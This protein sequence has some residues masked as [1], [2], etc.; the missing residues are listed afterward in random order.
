MHHETTTR[1][2]SILDAV[3]AA[4][5]TIESHGIINHVN[6]ATSRLFGYR[7]NEIVGQNV[8]VLM[9]SP[10][11]EEHDQYLKNHL[12]TG[13]NKIIGIG[14]KVLGRHK[15]GSTFA[16]HLSVAR[17]VEHDQVFFTG[18]IH[19]LSELERE[20]SMRSRLGQIVEESVN[21]I[22]TF[23]VNT[24]RF[25]SANRQALNNLGYKLEELQTMTPVDIVQ[26]LSEQ[27][28]KNTIL[29]LTSGEEQRLHLA[30]TLVR[31]DETQYDVEVYLHLTKAFDPPELVAIVKDVSEQNRMLEALRQS[32]K[33]E[34]IGNLTGGIAHDFN[35]ILTV[36]MGNLELLDSQ[37][38]DP[39]NRELLSEARD[40]V[41]MGSR[42][43]KRLLAFAR[44]S[45]LAP[46]RFNI[47]ALVE[48][49][50]EMLNRTL[51]DSIELKNVLNPS[52]WYC[53]VDIS[54]L[55]NA[56]VNLAINARDAM[57]DGG[58]L[59]IETE[60]VPL[61]ADSLAGKSIKPGNYVRL[62]VTDTGTGIN[63]KVKDS[64]FEPFVSTKTEQ[65]G[66]GLGLSMVYGFIK[67]SDGHIF[68]YSDEGKGAVFSMYLPALEVDDDSQLEDNIVSTDFTDTNSKTILVAEDD[69]KVRKLTVRRLHLMGHRVI[70]A[71][72]GEEA[73]KLLLSN[74]DVDLVFSD[75]VMSKGMSGYD[76]AL[77]IKEY[78]PDVPVLLT[79][80]Y[81]E[82][83]VNAE[84]LAE[85]GLSL[86]RKPYP[87]AELSEYLNRI[88]AS[89][90]N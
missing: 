52:L 34:S 73:F 79:S 31:L 3:D 6:P 74:Q 71:I 49:I 42:L 5:I 39:N 41:N 2:E 80:G 65:K 78:R 70:E 50:S 22:Y 30:E 54:E 7:S 82:D 18:I 12:D 17:Y 57:P 44:R 27:G 48:D 45:P 24:F 33:M 20:R 35:N 9:P 8:K 76:L 87:Q 4:I 32:Q 51:G 89:D 53:Y 68:V 1:L 23:D 43:T 55:E 63:E 40:A 56:L 88:F 81:A 61:D 37:I 21:E 10:Y 28:L 75:V 90:R 69:E 11:R 47:N 26:G 46:K 72:N 67:Q 59:I 58:E 60:N 13:E 38:E 66:S 83:I 16:I 85:S 19:D 84:K 62:S 25:S 77:K 36:V 15:N 86:L 29:P 14:R 64:I